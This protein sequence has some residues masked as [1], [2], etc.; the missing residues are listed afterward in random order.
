MWDESLLRKLQRCKVLRVVFDEVHCVLENKDHREDYGKMRVFRKF[1]PEVPYLCLS[2]SLSR[3][4]V[5]LLHQ[6]IETPRLKVFR[7]RSLNRGNLQLKV[8]RAPSCC[9]KWGGRAGRKRTACAVCRSVVH[10]L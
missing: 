2:A 9:T 6:S 5:P 7:Q 8:F 1:L 4:Q 10:V 3:A